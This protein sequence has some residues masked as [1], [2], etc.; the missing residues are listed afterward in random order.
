MGPTPGEL[1]GVRR[2]RILPLRQPAGRNP[3]QSHTGAESSQTA[4][5]IAT[6]GGGS[7]PEDE[8]SDA[9]DDSGE[10]SH[11][12]STDS[13]EEEPPHLEHSSS[14]AEDSEDGHGDEHARSRHKSLKRLQSYLLHRR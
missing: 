14:E 4:V 9:S 3:A 2:A 8:T 12:T 11:H 1:T 6:N 10:E 7:D 13:D 5:P